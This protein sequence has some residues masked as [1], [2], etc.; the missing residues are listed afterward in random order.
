MFLAGI[1]MVLHP[2]IAI[3]FCGGNIASVQVFGEAKM[4]CCCGMEDVDCQDISDYN[5]LI[6]RDLHETCCLN[7]VLVFSTDDYQTVGGISIAPDFDMTASFSDISLNYNDLNIRLSNYQ[8][9]FPPGGFARFGA[10]IL[11]FDC[12]LRI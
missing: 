6:L 9:F 12:V 1:L 5:G 8:S 10:D 11:T 3:H 4:V 2:V 7:E